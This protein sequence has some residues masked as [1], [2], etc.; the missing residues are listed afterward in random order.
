MK[1]EDV[2]YYLLMAL[3]ICCLT[4]A[5]GLTVGVTFLALTGCGA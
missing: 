4:L 5:A 1:I 2:M 3:A